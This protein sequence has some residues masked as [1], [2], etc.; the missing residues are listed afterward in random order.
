MLSTHLAR[1]SGD[2][3]AQV[4][5]CDHTTASRIASGQ[6]GATFGQW[7]ALVDLLGFK[8]VRKDLNCI[9]SDELAML[10]RTYIRAHNVDINWDDPE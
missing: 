4:C 2:E 9:A 10:R 7:C 3:I 1:L 6:R 5:D 8:L